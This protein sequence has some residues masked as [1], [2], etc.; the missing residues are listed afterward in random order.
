MRVTNSMTYRSMLSAMQDRLQGQFDAQQALSTGVKFQHAKDDPVAAAGVLRTQDLLA[1]LQSR[2]KNLDVVESKTAYAESRLG[3][4]TDTLQSARDLLVRSQTVALNTEDRDILSEQL[5]GLA[6]D[7]AAIGNT[8]DADGRPLFGGT[9]ANLPFSGGAGAW[10]LDPGM[11]APIQVPVSSARS[12]P[13]GVDTRAVFRD[14]SGTVDLATALE[15]MAATVALD[16]P[17][18]AGKLARRDALD[19]SLN[20]MDAM[21]ARTS[22]ARSSAGLALEAVDAIREANETGKFNANEELA[23]IRDADVAEEVT[24]L[25]NESA[26]LDAARAVF[27]RLEQ[28]SLFD[29]LR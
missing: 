8:R 2:Q 7:V 12:M 26:S 20:E 18:E 10:S 21:L 13:V 5:R 4:L 16:P 24:K 11:S 22:R 29:Y 19:V 27:Q 6:Q 14:S 15:N 9:S 25:A 23:R 28:Q 1:T 3:D 17:D